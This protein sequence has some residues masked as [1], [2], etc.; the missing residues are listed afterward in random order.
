MSQSLQLGECCRCLIRHA[1]AKI[2]TYLLDG[3]FRLLVV[4][5][6]AGIGGGEIVVAHSVADFNRSDL[7][8]RRVFFNR[9]RVFPF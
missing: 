9:N 7:C 8:G 4:S 3:L 1:V 2:E 6:G 5:V